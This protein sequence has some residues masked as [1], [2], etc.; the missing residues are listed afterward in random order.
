MIAIAAA[1]ISVLAA[2]GAL[3]ATWRET[4]SEGCAILSLGEPAD[5]AIR[6]RL[7]LISSPAGLAVR[8]HA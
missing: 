2:L 8:P 3:P 6:D 4:V 5:A 1:L 7:V